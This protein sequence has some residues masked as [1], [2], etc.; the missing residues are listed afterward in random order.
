MINDKKELEKKNNDARVLMFSIIGILTLIV[1]ISG[2]T[3]AYFAATATNNNTIKGNSGYVANPLTLVITESSAVASASL[4]L[5]PQVDSFIGNAANST[6][7]CIDTNGNAVCQHYK[8]TVTNTT[9]NS[10]YLDGH[11]SLTAASMPNLK[12]SNCSAE[13][14][15]TSNSYYTPS[16]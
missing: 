10:Y 15:C 5:I 11:M 6:K 16:F 14:V 2:A 4:K 1:A 12:W 13:W 8:I 9:T 3:F 7:K